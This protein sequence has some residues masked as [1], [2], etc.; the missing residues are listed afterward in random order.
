MALLELVKA[1]K[2]FGGLAAVSNLDLELNKG[3]ILGLIGP[4]GSGKTTVFNLIAGF[5]GLT[6]GQVIFKG[7]DIT[8]LK[9][10]VVVKKGLGRTFQRSTLFQP[11]STVQ[12]ALLGCYVKSGIGFWESL[13]NTR[14]NHKKEK[15]S[16]T[17][18][19]GLLKFVGLDT[20]KDVLAGNL[21]YGYQRTLNLAIALGTDPELLLLDE[22]LTALNPERVKAIQD[23]IRRIR[24]G[25]CTIVVI[26]HNMKA[27]FPIC[28]R[29]V[30]LD[31]G[32]KIAEG[33]PQE[34]QE[35]PM[36]IRIYLGG[37]RSARDRR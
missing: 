14:G 30:V 36:V 9:P 8:N 11:Q 13:F 17:K 25:G 4:N 10:H 12:N 34:V 15:A 1:T 7:K 33:K 31:A 16:E 5:L 22:P 28:D 3:E 19:M 2:Y 21:S 23:L 37:V 32:T 24:D 18:A 20:Q 29:V 35:N 26:E 6:S 27:L